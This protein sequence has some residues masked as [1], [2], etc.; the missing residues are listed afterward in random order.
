MVELRYE[1]NENFVEPNAKTNVVIAAF[2]TAYARLKLYGVLYQLQE[3][4]LYYDTDSVIFVSKPDEPE[5]PLGPYLGQLASELKEGHITSFISGGPKN[6]CCKS[7]TKCNVTGQVTVDI[8]LKI[9]R[10]TRTK[11]I[12]TK[13]MRKDYRI[14]YDKRFIV[15]DYKT[16]SYG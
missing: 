15:D 3:R 8:P 4:V 13:R 12:E 10:N 16:L 5:P 9:T 6:Y 7:S 2:T 1:Y 11:N 14:V